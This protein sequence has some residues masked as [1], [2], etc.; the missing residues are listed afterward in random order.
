[1][2]HYTVDELIV[3]WKREELTGEQMVGQVVQALATH[4][5]RLRAV[6]RHVLEEQVVAEPAT[7]PLKVGTKRR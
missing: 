3:R 7:E 2:T 6:E 5:Q 4:E 1:M